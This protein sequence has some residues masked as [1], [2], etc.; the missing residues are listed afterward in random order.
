MAAQLAHLHPAAPGASDRFS[1]QGM[2]VREISSQLGMNEEYLRELIRNFNEAGFSALKQRRRYGR[3]PRLSEEESSLSVEIETAP[4]KRLV[5]R[6]ISG[7]R[8][9]SRS[10]W[11]PESWFHQ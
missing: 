11:S 2:R 7:R 4:P 8:G 1:D 6:L 9:S 5:V 3:P 10:S